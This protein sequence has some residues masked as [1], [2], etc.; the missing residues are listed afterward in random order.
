MSRAGL[1]ALAALLVACDGPLPADAGPPDSGGARDAGND[2][3]NDGGRDAG[4]DAGTDAGREGC[5]GPPGLY[6]DDA[7]TVLAAGVRPYSPR[8]ALWS[9]GDDKERFVYLPPGTQIDTSDPDMW[10]FPQGTRLYKTFAIDGVRLET[11]ILEKIG[12]ARSTDSWTMTA[13]AWSADQRSVTEVG[14]FGELDVLGTDHDVPSR[15]DC[16]RCHSL[17]Q[18]DGSV[19]F[20]AVQLNHDGAGVTLATLNDEG[21]LTAPIPVADA[22]VPGDAATQAA[23]GYLHANCGNCHGGPAPEHGLDLWIPVGAT[24]VTSTPTWT[25]A[26]CTC[27]VWVG[28]TPTGEVVNLRIAPGHPELSVATHRM[29]TRVAV[30]QMPPIGTA[31]IDPDGLRILSDWIES[32]D[33]TAN[34]CPHGC[35]WP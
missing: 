7:C 18:E 33:E 30:D 27:S 25:T 12:T 17:A 22:M 11:R 23:L 28:S 9:D 14:A 4:A 10:A 34:G 5:V 35:P 15:G 24:D 32:L 31:A 8:F 20:S 13:Y 2:A 6:A 3:G 26:V 16:I 1:I 19:G 21:W 29:N